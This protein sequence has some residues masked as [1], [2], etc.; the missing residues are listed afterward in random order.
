MEFF[1]Y[2]TSCRKRER[3]RV[4]QLIVTAI[5][6]SW[7]AAKAYAGQNPI[8]TENGNPGTSEWQLAN[9]ANDIDQQVKGFASA[10]S[11]NKGGQISFYVTVN[12]AQS[13]DI[14]VFR[15]G[16]YQGEGGRLMYESGPL[17]GF[18]Q[19][20][21]IMDA[22]TGLLVCPWEESYTLSVPD[23]WTSG[24][25]LAKLT[26]SE[27]YENYIIFTV[28]DDDRSAD[29][30]YQ[31]P[32]TTYQSYNSFPAGIGKS[33]YAFNSY[34]ANT[35]TGT[36]RAVKVSFDRPYWGSGAGDFLNWELDLVMWLE[37]K[38]YNITYATDIDLHQRGVELLEHHQALISAGHDEYWSK[39]M[40][41]A[42]EA[43]RDSGI[44]L[45]FFGSNAIYWQMRME[46][47]AD[48]EPDR[49]MVSY[50]NADLDP[51]TDPGLKT[52]RWRELGRA[53][54]ALVGVQFIA[55]N[56]FSADGSTNRDYV[57]INS[58]HWVYAK[59]G[60]S[61]GTHLPGLVG[62][63]ADALFPD[64]PQPE[65]SNYTLLSASPF[66]GENGE[67]VTA[68]SSIYQ[69]PSGAWVFATGTMSWSW[70]LNR[71][72]LANPA[73][74]TTT[75]NI[76]DRF[77]DPGAP[78]SEVCSIYTSSD[79]SAESSDSMFDAGMGMWADSSRW[80][81]GRGGMWAS[82]SHHGMGPHHG[83]G[84][85]SWRPRNNLDITS[86]LEVDDW[87]TITDVN[88]VNLSGSDMGGFRNLKI[89]LVSPDSTEVRLAGGCN[90]VSTFDLNLDD[91]AYRKLGRKHRSDC[92]P[93]DGD[94]YLPKELLE[95]FIGEQSGGTWT[96][97]ITGQRKFRRS[98]GSGSL[99]SWGLEICRIEE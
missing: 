23:D 35:I 10:T 53:E 63:E 72:G 56:E 1:N 67:E 52:V 93:D 41:D 43:A 3:G 21:P 76:L 42:A 73:I 74:Q 59:T 19:P 28:R 68:N 6:V 4:F 86:T 30:L 45:A 22:D 46:P 18:P 97:N 85:G 38:G 34:G 90:R 33:L 14:K 81:R 11:V 17:S 13:Y 20:G 82:S 96:L 8:V 79:L 60:L 80:R 40:Y 84:H 16:W 69:A 7:I 32:V 64:Y 98:S 26:N 94:S 99:D 83:W 75:A 31:Q 37:K 88:V 49:V 70:G 77:I 71:D 15:M 87:G 54:Q 95:S 12:P 92:L 62:Y 61:D 58:E 89:S 5:I 2:C 51:A 24:I 47:S 25:Y 66:T 48:G 36:P 29:F 91:D 27:G 9:W 50:K 78:S 44:D 57:V 65:S 39:P 55:D